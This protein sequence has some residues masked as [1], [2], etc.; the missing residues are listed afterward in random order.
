MS[1]WILALVLAGVFAAIGFFSGAIRTAMMLL[2][3][4]IASFLTGPIAPKLTGLMPKVG[5]KHPLWIQFSPYI[6]VFATVM[7][8][9]FGIGF[10]VHHKV[11]LIYKYKYDDF[12]RLKWERMNH[13]VGIS[14]GVLIALILFFN[15]S[16][17][18]YAGGYLTAQ[19]ADESNAANNPGWI[20]FLSAM[21]RDMQ[22]TGLDKSVAA[23]DKTP[24]QFYDF[25]DIIGLIYHNPKVQSRLANYPY[26]LSIGQLPEFQ[27]LAAD[28]DYNNMIFGKEPFGT[29]IN[30]PNTQK[31]IANKAIVDQFRGVDVKDLEHYLKTGKSKYDEEQILGRWILDKDAV[32]T[33]IRKTQPDLRGD[34]LLAIKKGVEALPEI[35]LINT[36]DN[37]SIVKAEGA[38]AAAAPPADG[39]QPAPVPTPD[40][41]VDRYRQFQRPGQGG[42][43]AGRPPAQRSPGAAAAQAAG[44][45]SMQVIKLAGEGEWKRTDTGGYEVTLNDPSGKPQSLTATIQE[46]ELTLSKGGSAL[47]F[48]RAE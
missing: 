42:G 23:L 45:A 35:T 18:A 21:R 30:H 32:L 39:S 38:E 33:F 17:V 34:Q 29:I 20:K 16:K 28:K 46:D 43:A 31:L 11:G 4:M 26:F 6:I 1:I 47:V 25:A 14:V 27:E 8:I 22:A 37:K 15:V 44:A 48:Y 2:G 5:I 3:V 36:L 24:P 10:A 40:P 9:I 13:H 41:T 12:S 19:L 7:L